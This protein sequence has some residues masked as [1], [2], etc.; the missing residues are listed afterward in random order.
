MSHTS[1]GGEREGRKRGER[2]GARERR[3]EKK[4]G[5]EGAVNTYEQYK[6]MEGGLF[7][8]KSCAFI[9]CESE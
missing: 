7:H 1:G 5:R 2:G 6:G 8:N 3:G 4:D 9:H